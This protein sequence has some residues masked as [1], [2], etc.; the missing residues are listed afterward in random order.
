MKT[1]AINTAQPYEVK[2]GS[3][4]LA[5][6]GKL[7]TDKITTCTAVIVYPT[8]RGRAVRRLGGGFISR[9]FFGCFAGSSR[10]GRNPKALFFWGICWCFC[11][12]RRHRSDLIHRARRRRY[13]RP[14][15]V[16][17]GGVS[18][19]DSLSPAPTTFLRG[20]RLLRGGQDGA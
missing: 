16:R 7:L 12:E 3:G 18:A 5:R 6:A 9:G 11:G 10:R 19:G 2:I 20:G 13:R 4:L 1:V 14:R 15:R 8:Q 17:G